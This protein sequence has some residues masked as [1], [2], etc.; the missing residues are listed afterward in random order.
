MRYGRHF[1]EKQLSALSL[2]VL[3]LAGSALA[4][5]AVA[6]D[7]P[8]IT[9][10]GSG[11]TGSGKHVVLVSG[12]EEYRSEESMPQLAKILA[13]HHGFD[14]TVLFPINKE[15][16]E[17]DP[18]AQDN[19]PGLKA[20]EKADLMVIFT[21]FRELPD[22]DMKYIIAHDDKIGFKDL[23]YVPWTDMSGGC[24]N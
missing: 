21:R 6:S 5:T 20:L 9:Y 11:G 17:I 22:E 10:K 7:S 13:V 14:C 15:T 18:G 16:G 3:L 8:W 12:D 4:E 19:I 2:L 23:R 1:D 24:I